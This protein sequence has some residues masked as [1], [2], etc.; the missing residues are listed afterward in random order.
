MF[1]HCAFPRPSTYVCFPRCALTDADEA[2]RRRMEGL[3]EGHCLIDGTA[4]DLR[5]QIMLPT[6]EIRVSATDVQSGR[7]ADKTFS[8]KD[9]GLSAPLAIPAH[10]SFFDEVTRRLTLFH[11]RERN[12]MILALG[13][14]MRSGN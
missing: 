7:H 12:L 1:G 10:L 2:E 5:I 4:C 8:A 11:S 9:M 3:V 14:E 13:R 6:S